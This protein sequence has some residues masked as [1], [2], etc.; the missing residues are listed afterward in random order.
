MTYVLDLVIGFHIMKNMHCIDCAGDS[1]A[2]NL[3]TAQICIAVCECANC[4]HDFWISCWVFYTEKN[5]FRCF[6]FMLTSM[7]T[8]M[9]ATAYNWTRNSSIWFHVVEVIAIYLTKFRKHVFS[10]PPSFRTLTF[11]NRVSEKSKSWKRNC[12]SIWVEI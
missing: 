8:Y 1:I 2:Q 3:K 7:M 12:V 11:L 9:M 5:I 6:W 10:E 4:S